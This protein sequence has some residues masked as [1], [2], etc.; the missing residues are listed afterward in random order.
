MERARGRADPLTTCFSRS[1]YN[2]FWKCVQ[3]G[4]TYLFV[5]LC[6][7][8]ERPK[9]TCLGFRALLRAPGHLPRAAGCRAITTVLGSSGEVESKVCPWVAAPAAPGLIQIT[10]G[11]YRRETS[12]H[13]KKHRLPQFYDCAA[14]RNPLSQKAPRPQF[15][16]PTHAHPFPTRDPARLTSR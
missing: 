2:A 9:P 1:E 6:K 12:R 15:A 5:Q 11:H 7:V 10:C 16:T 8:R 14:L 13:I 3:A 4:V